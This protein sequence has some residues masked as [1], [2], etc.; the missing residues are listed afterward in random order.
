MVLSIFA[1]LFWV[2]LLML[3][4]FALELLRHSSLQNRPLIAHALWHTKLDIGLV[5]MA[6]A[7]CLYAD[8]VFGVLG[9][10][11]A[12]RGAR[13][14]SRFAA[15]KNS[16]RGVLLTVDDLGLFLK[17]LFKTG[18]KVPAPDLAMV[19]KSDPA[20]APSTQCKQTLPQLPPWNCPR[21][22]DWVS[23]SFA[24]LCLSALLLAPVLTGHNISKVFG[25]IFKEMLP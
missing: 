20:Q 3:A 18:K 2:V 12:A 4:H 16:L 9:L 24:V 23:L 6:L 11:Q 14:V 13:V 10:G 15:L 19:P 22:G 17:A 5:L 7:I 8:T 25:F 21:A 1:G